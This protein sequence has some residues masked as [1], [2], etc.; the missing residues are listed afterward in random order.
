M[1]IASGRG[2]LKRRSAPLPHIGIDDL[3]AGVNYVSELFAPHKRIQDAEG[4]DGSTNHG[5][6]PAFA[7]PNNI[8]G[9][10]SGNAS[11]AQ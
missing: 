4:G 11:S 2:F 1:R 10:A 6:L 5:P 3:L 8:R 9:V 7:Q